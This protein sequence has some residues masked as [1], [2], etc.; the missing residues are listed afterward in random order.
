MRKDKTVQISLTIKTPQKNHPYNSLA[1]KCSETLPKCNI[2]GKQEV[3]P[4]FY[5]LGHDGGENPLDRI[6]Y[7]SERDEID[8]SLPI[9]RSRDRNNNEF[10]GWN[11]S[12]YVATAMRLSGLKMICDTGVAD[13]RD[14][15]M[16]A[17]NWWSVQRM[18][19]AADLS[20]SCSCMDVVDLSNPE[21]EI[22][23]G[24]ILLEGGHSSIIETSD[25]NFMGNLTNPVLSNCKDNE[26]CLANIQEKCSENILMP[27]DLRFSINHS[28]DI[29][30]GI[31][32]ASMNF[33]NYKNTRSRNW[34]TVRRHISF[35]CKARLCK[36][37]NLM[38][39]QFCKDSDSNANKKQD[40]LST[41][42]SSSRFF[43]IIRHNGSDECKA[44]DRPKLKN[45]CGEKCNRDAGIG[46]LYS[47]S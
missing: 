29:A 21:E 17:D 25:Q 42:G 18:S 39:I 7:T 26:S 44:E 45:N 12:E 36:L 30:G 32:P 6:P 41:P 31:G 40:N 20:G 35:L 13:S 1:P 34:P 28:S 2:N 9:F 43:K 23:P 37:H 8:P 15:T 14:N 19:E 3:C 24:D 47:S 11:C 22:K 5:Y 10:I 33:E 46:C 38:G 16:S 27:S 4:G